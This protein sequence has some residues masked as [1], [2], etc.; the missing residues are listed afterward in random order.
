MLLPKSFRREEGFHEKV[1]SCVEVVGELKTAE[2][3]ICLIIVEVR[4]LMRTREN[5]MKKRFFGYL[6]AVLLA[7]CFVVMLVPNKAFNTEKRSFFL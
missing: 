4:K 5:T 6:A 2:Q 1:S 3:G 7:I